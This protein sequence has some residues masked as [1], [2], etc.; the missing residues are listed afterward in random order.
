MRLPVFTAV[1]VAAVVL[2]II[3]VDRLPPQDSPLA[4][5]DPR[6]PIGWATAWQ[7]ARLK[8]DSDECRALLKRAGVRI[9]PVSDSHESAFCG[10]RDAVDVERSNIPWSLAPLRL[11]C[12]MAAALA[13]WERRV[14]MPAAEQHLG[15]KVTR[16]DHFGTYACR[17]VAGNRSGRP[18]QHATANAID[19][20]AFRLAD[21]RQIAVRAQWRQDTDEAAFLHAV[22]DN[23]CRIFAAV[24]GPDYNDAHADH[25]HLDMGP[26]SICR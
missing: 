6:R 2:G 19:V 25:F 15:S 7:L 13:L 17:R 11:S 18:S 16:I 20:A 22:R 24:L 14:V 3:V 12:P 9:E 8:G 4:A 21:G 26:Y 1:V 5:F 10:F 23:S